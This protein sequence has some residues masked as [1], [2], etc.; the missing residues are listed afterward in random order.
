MSKDKY[1]L[2]LDNKELEEGK[3]FSKCCIKV[4]NILRL[5]KYL[6]IKKIGKIKK[7]KI[8]QILKVS[9]EIIN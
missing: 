9:N 8:K 4:E 6:V 1:S 5:D 3:L 7:E 2:K